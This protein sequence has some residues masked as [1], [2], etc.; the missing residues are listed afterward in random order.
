[1]ATFVRIFPEA[2]RASIQR[3]GIRVT[4]TKSHQA[5][6]VFVSP[7]TENYVHTHQLM[8][9]VQRVRNVPK[10]AARIRIPDTQGVRIG[11]Y[12]ERHIEVAAAEAIAI[13]RIHW[14]SR[15]LEVIIPRGVRA[16]EIIKIYRPPKVVGWRYFPDAHGVRPCRCEM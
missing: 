15:G 8:R 12:N 13:A 14:D 11:K 3:S 16:T 9:E 6:G 4:K 2:D 1:M 7:V 10:L 5:A